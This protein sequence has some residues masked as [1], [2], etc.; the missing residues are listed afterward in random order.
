MCS[1]EEDIE[2]VSYFPA[3]SFCIIVEDDDFFSFCCCWLQ[4]GSCKSEDK[5]SVSAGIKRSKVID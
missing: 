5:V 3:S 1:L 4:K 2:T